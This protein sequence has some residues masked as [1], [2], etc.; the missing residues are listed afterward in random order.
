VYSPARAV[1]LALNSN[2]DMKTKLTV[3]ISP[4]D[5]LTTRYL[6]ATD[7]AITRALSRAGRPDLIDVGLGIRTDDRVKRFEHYNIIG[8]DA[9][10]KH[11]TGMYKNK[12]KGRADWKS[13]EFVL[14]FDESIYTN[15]NCVPIP[16]WFAKLRNYFRIKKQNF[17]CVLN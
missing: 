7:C 6:N 14:E 13:K 10:T 16:Q 5:I 11:V 8:Y 17:A 15:A 9:M 12:K 4:V 3:V 1:G 2:K